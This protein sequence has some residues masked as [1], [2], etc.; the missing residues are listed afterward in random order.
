VNQGKHARI[1]EHA[2]HQPIHTH[3]SM[4]GF[5]VTQL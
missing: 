2:A 4:A 3:Y 5:S 1:A